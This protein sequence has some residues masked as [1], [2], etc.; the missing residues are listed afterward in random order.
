MK[1]ILHLCADLGSDSEPYRKAGYQVA[2]VGKR[3]DV[4]TFGV[5]ENVHGVIANPP[6]THFSLARTRAK[7][8]RDIKGGLEIVSACLRIIYACSPK[9][10]VL[11]NPLGM[12]RRYLGRPKITIQPYWFGDSWSKQTDLWGNFNIPIFSPTRLT[13]EEITAMRQNTRKLQDIGLTRSDKRAIA[14]PSF[15]KAFKEVNP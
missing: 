5:V 15:W 10:W 3:E 2:Y 9:W 1:K 13:Q 11:E 6:C 8:P 4:R 14:P 7:T 12:L